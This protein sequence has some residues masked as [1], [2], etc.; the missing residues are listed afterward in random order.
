MSFDQ[1]EQEGPKPLHYK[2]GVVLMVAVWR[3]RSAQ[4][5]TTGP[6]EFDACRS[7]RHIAP[8]HRGSISA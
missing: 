2:L 7:T 3:R 1:Q 6:E 5:G 8:R 4:L